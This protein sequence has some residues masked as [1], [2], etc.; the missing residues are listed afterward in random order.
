MNASSRYGIGK[1]QC[2]LACEIPFLHVTI[3]GT[4]MIGVFRVLN[5]AQESLCFSALELPVQDLSS[6]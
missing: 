2:F 3:T 4:S 6:E 1:E 5:S